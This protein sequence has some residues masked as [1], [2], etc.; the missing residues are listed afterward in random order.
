MDTVGPTY[1][2]NPSYSEHK[3]HKPHILVKTSD[4]NE[5]LKS[6]SPCFSDVGYLGINI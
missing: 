2:H 1:L 6:I 4:L 3:R 5:I